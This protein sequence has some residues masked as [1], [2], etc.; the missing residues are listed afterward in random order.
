MSIKLNCIGKKCLFDEQQPSLRSLFEILK[1]PFKEL[2]S[3]DLPFRLC[4]NRLNALEDSLLNKELSEDKTAELLK[5]MEN[6]LFIAQCLS[7]AKRDYL[8]TIASTLSRLSGRT[9]KAN[10]E[11]ALKIRA[12]KTTGKT[13]R[14]SDRDKRSAGEF[15][16]KENEIVSATS[17][18]RSFFNSSPATFRC[19][20]KSNQLELFS[21]LISLTKSSS[22]ISNSAYKRRTSD[23]THQSRKRGS[24]GRGSKPR[25]K[26]VTTI[27]I[28]ASPDEPL[29]CTCR[30]LVQPPRKSCNQGN[31]WKISFGEMIG[32]DN[33]KC[34]IEWFHFECVDLKVKP[35]GKWYCPQCRGDKTNLPKSLVKIRKSVLH[36]SI[37]IMQLMEIINKGTYEIQDVN[38]FRE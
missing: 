4:A 8:I 28:S 14:R 1:D 25:K 16:I 38:H 5:Q 33:E 35:K 13:I 30:Q 32:C 3:L 37:L 10:N 22:D 20:R 27:S 6:E 24:G 9:E 17:S 7:L 2:R 36:E 18:D 34:E 31:S 26:Q 19:K 15:T 11:K 21:P 12:K 29:Y 23:S